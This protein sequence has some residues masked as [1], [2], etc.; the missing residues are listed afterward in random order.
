MQKLCWK[1]SACSCY[2]HAASPFNTTL[3]HKKSLL[4]IIP[5]NIAFTHFQTLSSWPPSVHFPVMTLRIIIVLI[6]ETEKKNL[7]ISFSLFI[8][9]TSPPFIVTGTTAV[10]SA[11]AWSAVP[12]VWKIKKQNQM[13][14]NTMKPWTYAPDL[15]IKLKQCL[16]FLLD[17]CLIHG[18]Q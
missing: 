14:L 4:Q 18:E 8:F 6:I 1:L 3:L 9:S 15:T 16:P 5:C 17:L 7:Y 13:G 12:T 10:T 2:I 11:T